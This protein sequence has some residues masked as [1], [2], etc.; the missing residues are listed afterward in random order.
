MSHSYIQYQ[1]A[2]GQQRDNRWKEAGGPDDWGQWGDQ[3]SLQR[4]PAW[5]H[6]CATGKQRIPAQDKDIEDNRNISVKQEK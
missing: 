4:A 1:C 2:T 6:Q 5:L 3:S